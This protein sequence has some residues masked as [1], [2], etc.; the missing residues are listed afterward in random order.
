M[1]PEPRRKRE[2]KLQ[3][4]FDAEKVARVTQG[5]STTGWGVRELDARDRVIQIGSTRAP[6]CLG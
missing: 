5:E 2:F 1:T 6:A 4:E 3:R